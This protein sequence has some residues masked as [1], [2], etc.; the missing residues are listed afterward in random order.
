MRYSSLDYRNCY[1]MK[2]NSSLFAA[3]LEKIKES[4]SSVLPVA[5]IVLV[6]YLTPLVS[7]TAKELTA[8]LVC[9]FFLVLGI[10][11]FNLGADL[12][13][14]PMGEH[15]G[16]GLMKSRKLRVLFSVCFLM[17]VLI[18]VAEPDLSVLASQASA[19]INEWMLILTIGF[20]IGLFLLLA[21]VKIVFK[22]DFRPLSF[23]FI[24]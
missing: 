6:I 18:T 24:C 2:N 22:K 19:V 17:G 16:S 1:S 8:F 21:V 15:I 13:M 12:A 14:T 20:G 4:L 5:L 7:L 9:T 11:L 23:S 10:A 3:L